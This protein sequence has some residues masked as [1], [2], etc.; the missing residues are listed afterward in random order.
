MNNNHSHILISVYLG[1][2][3]HQQENKSLYAPLLWKS[4]VGKVRM[5]VI[6]QSLCQFRIMTLMNL[7]E[8]AWDAESGSE[9]GCPKWESLRTSSS[10]NP[11]LKSA[12]HSKA[13]VM[14]DLQSFRKVPSA[15]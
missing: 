11:S 15:L 6:C 5:K 10:L 9:G 4:L 2:N 14:D 1:D 13:R 12:T 8:G 3:S 7:H